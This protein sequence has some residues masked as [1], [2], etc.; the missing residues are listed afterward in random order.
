H[1]KDQR[2]YTGFIRK[3]GLFASWLVRNDY[4]VALFGSDIGTDPLA[5]EDLRRALS[6]DPELAQRPHSVIDAP[7][8]STEQ[9]LDHMSSM[10]YIVTCRLHGVIFAHLLNKP[11]LAIAH[12]PKVA[13]QMTDIGLAR[14]C[15]D[16]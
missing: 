8:I 1:E 10:D 16:I 2:V 3:L 5:I 12:H 4:R 7:A 15:L 13:A 11:V 9:L 6:A 14:Y